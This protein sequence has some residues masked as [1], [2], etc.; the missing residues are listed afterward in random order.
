MKTRPIL[1]ALAALFGAAVLC[2][3]AEDVNLGTW[4]LNEAKSKLSPGTAKNT[5]VVYT[6][7]GESV[8]VT[9]D[10]VDTTG[11]PAHNEW[12]GKF[13]GKDYPVTGDPASDMRAYKRVNDH[14][15]ALTLKNGGKVTATG[16]IVVSAD[17]KSR[18][19]TT[20]GTDAKGMKISSSS[21][22]DKQ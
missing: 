5:T 8:K 21:V 17:G 16:R 6:A 10:G 20:S 4:K 1:L 15:L 22:Y 12:T 19:V 18:T 2:F 9:V 13:D 11:K 7:E 3:A 14:T